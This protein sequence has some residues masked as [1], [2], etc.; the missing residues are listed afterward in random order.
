MLLWM[1]VSR[2]MWRDSIRGL[3]LEKSEVRQSCFF[4]HIQLKSF[5]FFCS[6]LQ[7]SMW[8]TMVIILIQTTHIY[9]LFGLHLSCCQI[10]LNVILFLF[11]SI[12]TYEYVM[13]CKICVQIHVFSRTIWALGCSEALKEDE[14]FCLRRKTPEKRLM[15][16]L[17]NV[18]RAELVAFLVLI[19]GNTIVISAVCTFESKLKVFEV[20]QNFLS[21]REVIHHNPLGFW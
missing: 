1:C 12:L 15:D 3:E 10:V 18:E 7:M 6:L 13:S 11:V 5:E 16:F 17:Q 4:L 20:T 21:K 14:T 19:S 2:E 8:N 9:I